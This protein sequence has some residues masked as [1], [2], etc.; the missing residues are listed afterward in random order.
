M[1]R[2]KRVKR[3]K[4]TLKQKIS[5]VI[6]I[7]SALLILS[8]ISTSRNFFHSFYRELQDNKG[9]AVEELAEDFLEMD[10]PGLS[11][12]IAKNIALNEPVTEETKPYYA[13]SACYE[14][15]VDFYMYSQNGE[16]NKAEAA[17]AEFE[18][19]E[20]KMDKKLFLDKIERIR[21]VY[22]LGE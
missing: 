2:T 9:Y 17:K 20:A 21:E 3:P 15:A 10:Y 16:T 14:S 13:F 8:V 11:K 1:K 7:V 5:R 6:Y 22:L 4:L 18:E 19:N 12:K